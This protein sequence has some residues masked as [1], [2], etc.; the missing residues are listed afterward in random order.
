M[1]CERDR[2]ITLIALDE[3]FG[4]TDD[5][6]VDDSK[7]HTDYGNRMKRCELRIEDC[8]GDESN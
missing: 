1:V 7:K 5:G 3:V 2:S 6:K 8:S 4:I